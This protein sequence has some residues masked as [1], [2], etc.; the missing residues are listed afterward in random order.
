MLKILVKMMGMTTADIWIT[1]LLSTRGSLT[2]L[3]RIIRHRQSL[4]SSQKTDI[5]RPEEEKSGI[6]GH[7]Q[8]LSPALAVLTAAAVEASPF[9]NSLALTCKLHFNEPI[10]PLMSQTSPQVAGPGL[11]VSVYVCA[12]MPSHFSCT[13]SSCISNMEGEQRKWVKERPVIL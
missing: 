11:V 10:S 1:S 4:L 9:T 8:L 3:A 5:E 13:L 6:V 2:A 7:D 12:L